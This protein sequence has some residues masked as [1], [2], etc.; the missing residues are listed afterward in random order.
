M[1]LFWHSR[2]IE[3]H[4]R[5]LSQKTG[6]HPKNKGEERT[7]LTEERGDAGRALSV[8]NITIGEIWEFQVQWIFIG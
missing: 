6:A 2:V 5:K 8:Y 4:K 3:A 7:I 1:D